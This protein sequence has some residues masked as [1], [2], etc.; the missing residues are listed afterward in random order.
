MTI[1]Y[2]YAYLRTKDSK[3]AKA[4]TPY[5]IEKGKD[6]RAYDLNRTVS[7]PKKVCP[8]CNKEVDIRNFSRSHGDRCKFK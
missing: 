4:G 2:V 1:Y 8:Q 7:V 6:K 3:T 5:Y